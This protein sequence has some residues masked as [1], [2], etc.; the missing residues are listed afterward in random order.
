MPI[1]SR[2]IV[3]CDE[4]TDRSL[5]RRFQS[6]SD[7][8]STI[9][10]NNL[11][12]LPAKGAIDTHDPGSR[13]NMLLSDDRP[14]FVFVLDGKPILVVELTKHGYTGDNPLQRFTRLAIAAEGG[15]AVIYFTPFSRVRDD[16]LDQGVE[17]PSKRRVNTDMFKGMSHLAEIF[18]IP[19]VALDWP[20]NAAGLPR[21]LSARLDPGEFLKICGH[22]IVA[23]EKIS[24]D[25]AE[26]LATGQSIMDDPWVRSKLADLQKLWEVPNTRTS[27]VKLTLSRKELKSIIDRPAEILK[28]ISK[29]D[30]F[31]KDKPERLLLL[32]CIQQMKIELIRR[33]GSAPRAASSELSKVQ[34]LIDCNDS[35]ESAMFYQTGYKWRSDP[36][37]GVLVNIDYNQCRKSNGHTPRDRDRALVLF[38]PRVFL[39]DVSSPYLAISR[40]LAALSKKD[41]GAGISRLFVQRYGDKPT[42]TKYITQLLR[43][44]GSL[45][46]LWRDTTKQA[47]VFRYYCD[48]I[49]LGDAIIVGDSWGSE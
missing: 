11:K 36:H 22:L 7:F 24:R 9:P 25:L 12:I 5:F 8:L 44:K 26:R 40:S 2:L 39:S 27:A 14:D 37:C 17:N 46:G 19:M 6:H 47:R 31:F 21:S 43:G 35:F 34:E 1:P 48:L 32:E 18:K 28:R 15:C 23:M 29:T 4:E 3:Y 41:W 45:I 49:I 30:Y 33:N 13:I 16:E 10:N 20:T 38:W 42:A